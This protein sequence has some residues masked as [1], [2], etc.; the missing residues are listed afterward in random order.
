MA[1]TLCSLEPQFVLIEKDELKDEINDN[2]SMSGWSE[3]SLPSSVFSLHST[4]NNGNAQSPQPFYR[5][6]KEIKNDNKNSNN[7]N[8]NNN[9]K[10]NNNDDTMMLPDIS[11]IEKQSS[12]VLFSWA[13]VAKIQPTFIAPETN[14][15]VSH[16]KQIDTSNGTQYDKLKMK[17]LDL[18][19]LPEDSNI[20]E[21]DPCAT[22]IDL[23]RRPHNVGKKGARVKWPNGKNRNKKK[24]SKK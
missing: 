22:K 8:N 18:D 21:A 2:I 6:N 12:N 15:N 23:G 4:I 7:D 20:P 5:K 14:L 13:E 1:A 24:Q 10:I 9:N 11:Q 16:N 17:G 19:T 3:I